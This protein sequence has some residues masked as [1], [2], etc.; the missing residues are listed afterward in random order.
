MNYD[1]RKDLAAFVHDTVEAARDRTATDAQMQAMASV[2]NTLLWDVHQ[3]CLSYPDAG[4]PALD[5]SLVEP[6]L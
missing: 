1:I 3:R 6:A 5:E 2:A 4:E